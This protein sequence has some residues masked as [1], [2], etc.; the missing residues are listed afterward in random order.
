M[1]GISRAR[2]YNVHLSEH[3]RPL[4]T[5][6]PEDM[7][8]ELIF[9]YNDFFYLFFASLSLALYSLAMQKV[10]LHV[11]MCHV[12]LRRNAERWRYGFKS[13]TFEPFSR[14]FNSLEILFALHSS[15]EY[16]QFTSTCFFLAM[17]LCSCLSFTTSKAMHQDLERYKIIFYNDAPSLLRAIKS[18]EPANE[19]DYNLQ[20]FCGEKTCCGT[21]EANSFFVK[22]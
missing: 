16:L 15:P 20:M 19:I 18:F 17:F 6:I 10:C 5:N 13:I 3:R 11:V 8:R 9:R 12:G 1:L 22:T 2:M 4:H 14:K 7:T 21:N